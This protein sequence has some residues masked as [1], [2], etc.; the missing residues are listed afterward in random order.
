M[1]G[2]VQETLELWIAGGALMVPL[3]IL[4]G[5]IYF[6]IFELYLYMKKKKFYMMDANE[7][8][9][10]IDV[11][12]DAK[13]DVAEIIHYTQDGVKDMD[14]ARARFEEV[15]VSHLPVLQ[16]RLYFCNILVGAAP[17]T[18]LLGTVMGMLGTFFGLSVS[19]G[20]NTIDLVAGGI[21]EALITTQTGLV[22][23]IP[24][25]VMMTV[26]KKQIGELDSFFNRME[27]LTILKLEKN[28]LAK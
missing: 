17:L 20:G 13:G 22:L 23:A 5:V 21:S 27:I 28:N 18:G 19:T 26:V 14:G 12:K 1:E 16:R 11:P 8:G 7:L 24:A 6:A 3:A 9:H 25:Y 4:G 15:R 10:W 2:I